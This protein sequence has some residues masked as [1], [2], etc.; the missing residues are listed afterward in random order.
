MKFLKES[1]L[2]EEIELYYDDLEFEVS[3]GHYDW[4]TGTYGDK[5]VSSSLEYSIEE[6]EAVDALLEILEKKDPA[7]YDELSEMND[8]DFEKFMS[9][10]KINEL[11]EKYYDDIL[12]YFEDDAKEYAAE[13]YED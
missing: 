8:P 6:W 4:D 12:E 1:L 3:D 2:K 9:D 11:V 7:L 10:E 13:R 5:T